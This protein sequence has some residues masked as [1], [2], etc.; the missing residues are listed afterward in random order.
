[1]KFQKSPVPYIFLFAAIMTIAF[2]SSLT[3]DTEIN[4]AIEYTITNESN[5]II[6]KPI[7]IEEL[8]TEITMNTTE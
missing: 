7:I 6:I 3:V 4:Q 1:M 5:D 8:N 2:Y